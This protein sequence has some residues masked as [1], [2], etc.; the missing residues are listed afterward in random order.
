MRKCILSLIAV[1][2]FV[3]AAPSRAIDTLPSQLSDEAF[4]KLFTD[5]SE[6]GG[7]FTGEN[8]VS[9]ELKYAD[10]I[11]NLQKT[12]KPGDVYIGVGPEQNFNYIASTRPK[13]A[14]VID[15]R[16]QNAIEHLMYRA[17]FELSPDRATFLS[18]L[19]SR[20][21]PAGL[22]EISTVNGLMRAYS[23]LPENPVA[24]TRTMQDVR[25]KLER[26]HSFALSADDFAA[27]A[28][29][30]KVFS[31]QGTGTNYASDS[32]VG[33]RVARG[34]IGIFPTY[35]ALME[36]S[37]SNGKVWSY[38][39]SEETY[40]FVR[41]METKGL[42]VPVV[43]DFGGPKALRSIGQYVRDHDA[44]VHVFYTSNVETY[45]L[46]RNGSLPVVNGGWKAYMA[47]VSSLPTN[48]SSVFLRWET[49]QN[50]GRI[51]LIRDTLQADGDGKITTFADLIR[52]RK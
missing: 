37:D 16:R 2:F 18:R 21:R 29:I 49:T 44:I 5:F 39:S 13:M 9:N 25:N 28:K 41:D 27:I 15:I 42:I 8:Y 20:E 4:W 19:F 14:F 35:A 50:P 7:A 6:P 26:D 48:D 12:S 23:P 38:L 22:S 45:L 34:E 33:A 11:A 3:V 51:D 36:A 17:L 46:Q 30:L 10:L 24:F 47:N 40:R 31:Q 32:A 1:F 52:N 43:G